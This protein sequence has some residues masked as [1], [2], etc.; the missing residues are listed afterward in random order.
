MKLI[1]SKALFYENLLFPAFHFSYGKLCRARTTIKIPFKILYSIRTC[2]DVKSHSSPTYYCDWRWL[3]EVT[4][5]GG[6]FNEM[7]SLPKAG[8]TKGRDEVLV[9][10]YN[11]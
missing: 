8:N 10:E 2:T 3:L 1:K 7:T 4:G 5:Y 11:I 9:P 6:R